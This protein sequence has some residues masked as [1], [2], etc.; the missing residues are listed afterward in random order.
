LAAHPLGKNRYE[1]MGNFSFYLTGVQSQAF[2]AR[3][4]QDAKY[5][6]INFC[7]HH[8]PMP[9]TQSVFFS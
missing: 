8:V 7:T 5:A 9:K 6:K 3:F 2:T 4:T 1:K